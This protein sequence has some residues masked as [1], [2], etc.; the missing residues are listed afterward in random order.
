M[1]FVL[2]ASFAA[3]WFLPDEA[4]LATNALLDRLVGSEALVPSLFRHEMRN[5][6]LLA[7]R[8]GR[9]SRAKLRDIIAELGVAPFRD[10]GP[11]DD[12]EIVDLAIKHDLTAYDAAYLGLALRERLPLATLDRKLAAAARAE[13][14]AVLG[15]LGAS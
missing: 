9:L 6:M 14:V 13:N 8:R 4:S 3:S 2:D 11:G 1:P 15:P 12:A 10:C 5:L 7:H